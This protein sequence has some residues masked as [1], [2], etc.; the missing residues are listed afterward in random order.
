MCTST[1]NKHSLKLLSAAG[2]LLKAC[3]DMH[4]FHCNF[5]KYFFYLL[6]TYLV[7]SVHFLPLQ[8]ITKQNITNHSYHK[9][10]LVPTESAVVLQISC[11]ILIYESIKKKTA[12]YESQV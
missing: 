11:C 9:T 6:V 10:I 12:F 3:L 4:I 5:Y 1:A 7:D 8:G 2:I